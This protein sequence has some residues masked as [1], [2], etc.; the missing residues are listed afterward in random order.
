MLGQDDRDARRVVT[1]RRVWRSGMRDWERVGRRARQEGG[2]SMLVY[3]YRSLAVRERERG[4]NLLI[5]CYKPISQVTGRGHDGGVWAHQGREGTSL[6]IMRE[7]SM[8]CYQV[9]YPKG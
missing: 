9:D 3:R 2:K 4:V 1:G 6:G 5:D 8:V 7:E